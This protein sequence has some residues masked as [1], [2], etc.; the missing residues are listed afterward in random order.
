MKIRV[1]SGAGFFFQ[2]WEKKAVPNYFFLS[3][4]R[5]VQWLVTIGAFKIFVPP[6]KG[7]CGSLMVKGFEIR[8]ASGG[9]AF[10]AIFCRKCGVE[11][12]QVRV[13]MTIE[14][15]SGFKAWKLKDLLAVL[16]VARGAFKILML[17]AELESGL[18]VIESSFFVIGLQMPA[19]CNMASAALF[20]CKSL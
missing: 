10:G 2:I 16:I 6:F 17:A 7:K 4:S 9:M 18:I 14:T 20:I 12:I 5:A 15:K 3:V 19:L 11:L 8:K 1:T 13:A